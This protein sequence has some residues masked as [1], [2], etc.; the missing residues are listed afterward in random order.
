MTHTKKIYNFCVTFFPGVLP[1]IL[2]VNSSKFFNIYMH[3][4]INTSVSILIL[5]ECLMFAAIT[6]QFPSGINKASL[7]LNK[8]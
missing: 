1:D 2:S 6:T 3:I 5:Y 7:I 4:Y 8:D